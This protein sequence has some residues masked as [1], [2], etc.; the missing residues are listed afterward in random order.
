MTKAD[1][2]EK[3][4]HHFTSQKTNVG[5]PIQSDVSVTETKFF[6]QL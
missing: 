3:E 5:I 1:F 4:V 2:C 6:A